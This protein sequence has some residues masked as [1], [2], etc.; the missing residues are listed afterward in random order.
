MKHTA[1]HLANH[2]PLDRAEEGHRRQGWH[3][4]AGRRARDAGARRETHNWKNKMDSQ[5]RTLPA[6]EWLRLRGLIKSHFSF[7]LLLLKLAFKL[8]SRGHAWLRCY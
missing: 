1:H 8:R 7:A 6:I 5:A 2:R 4:S 3:C